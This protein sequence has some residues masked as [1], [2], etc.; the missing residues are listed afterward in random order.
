[1]ASK[2]NKAG[3]QPPQPTPAKK[4]PSA[5]L[6][7]AKRPS[8]KSPSAKVPPSKPTAETHAPKNPPTKISVKAPAQKTPPAKTPSA[9]LKQTLPAFPIHTC[10]AL[11]F[12]GLR[13]TL[14]T[15]N[16]YCPVHYAEYQALNAALKTAEHPVE[17]FSTI[18]PSRIPQLK[19]ILNL[20]LAII[21][22][23]HACSPDLGHVQRVLQL[24]TQLEKC[25]A[26]EA[27]RAMKSLSSCLE[28][29]A[30]I[31]QSQPC[32]EE[33]NSISS[34]SDPLDFDQGVP[35]EQPQHETN[36]LV[37]LA[38]PRPAVLDPVK[39]WPAVG[40]L[41]TRA[42]CEIACVVVD[43]GSAVGA[44]AVDKQQGQKWELGPLGELR[45]R[46][47]R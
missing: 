2:K 23:F 14:L 19:K 39:I 45:A 13:C 38:K 4:S 1:M 7:S 37:A 8:A 43:L 28:G 27:D 24:Q 35:I 6:P 31:Y 33:T 40:Q 29:D 20:R 32:V 25:K 5:K 44:C 30:S 9:I 3:A 46:A 26:A 15:T 12:H 21:H 16:P 11:E 36:Q 34:V 18:S 22:R 42:V 41:A 17:Q 47:V 10:P